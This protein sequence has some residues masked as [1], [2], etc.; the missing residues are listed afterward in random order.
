MQREEFTSEPTLLR[1][2][3]SAIREGVTVDN[4]CD[5]FTAVNHLYGEDIDEESPL[6]EGGEKLEE[7]QRSRF[8]LLSRFSSLKNY[9]GTRVCFNYS[10]VVWC[11]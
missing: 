3:C 5:L 10:G 8:P 7:V 2:L 1:K 6:E 11:Y 9:E 4:S